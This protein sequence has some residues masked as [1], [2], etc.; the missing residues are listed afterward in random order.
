MFARAYQALH[1]RELLMEE[2]SDFK[3]DRSRYDQAVVLQNEYEAKP[4]LSEELVRFISKTKNEP[5]WMLDIR[6]KGFKLF[7]N[8]A[9]PK[10]GPSLEKLDLNNII[11][12]VKP[13]AEEATRWEDV[14]EEIRKVAERIG[15]PEAERRA[16]G[17]AGFQFDSDMMY[18]KL[19]KEW[20]DHGVIFENMDVAVQ[21]YPELVKKYFMTNC[22]PVN[23]HKFIMLHAA[24]WSGGT[25]IYV[26]KGVRVGMPLQAYFRMN[27]MKGGQFE[28][29]LII[30]DEGGEVGYVE[31]CSSPVYAKD[32][33][34]AGCVEIHVLEGARVRYS[35][36][37]NWSKNT[38][39]LNT[40]RAIVHK[41]GIVEWINGNMGCL[42]GDSKVFTNPKGPV[43]IKDIDSGDKVYVWDDKT[44]RI[45][46][47]VVKNKIFSG[48][49][50]VYKI[51]AGGREI[52]ASANHPFLTLIRRKNNPLHKKG[53]FHYEWKPVGEL[54]TGDLVGITKKL[55]V[56]GKPKLLPEI[57]I[58]KTVKSRNQYSDFEMNTSHLYN[59][60]INIPKETNE[61]FMWLMGILLG[62]GFIDLNQNKINIAT[63][64]KEDYREEMCEIIRDL[65]NYEIT[66]K[67]ERYVI[68]NSKALCELFKKIGFDGN[69]DTKKVPDW[70]FTLPES[71]ILAFLAGY[72]DSD[73]HVQ[74]CAL[75]FT[76]IS[77]GLLEKIKL[78]GINVGFGV[79]RVFKHRE[80]GKVRILGNECNASASWRILFNGKKIK[81]LPIKCLAKKIKA[82]K[83][84]TRR[85]YRTSR[86]LNFSSKVNEEVGF[87]R[88]EKISCL[89]EKPTFDIEVENYHN[90]IANGL[91]VHN[92]HTTMLYPSSV[93]I[94][95]GA[96]SDSLGIAFAA[97]GQN[98]DTGSKVIHAAPNTYSTIKAKSISKDG[99]ITSYRGSVIVTKQA[100]N[101]KCSVVCDA[102]L[103]DEKSVSNTFPFM[104]IDNK[105][106]DIAH[107]A[108]V[109]KIGDDEIH[110]LQSRGLSEEQAMQM[111]VAGFIEPI[112]KALPLE[113]AVE[114]KKL[115]ELEMEGTVG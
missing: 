91:I 45:K 3:I 104:K 80:A 53:F 89:G 94:G 79:S 32:S 48:Y 71:Q 87:A 31:G 51:E 55:P 106:V 90:F 78:L 76:S 7:E 72:F 74:D 85:N 64:E 13:G 22:I 62:D 61:D 114:L 105:S 97:E 18:H 66:E 43:N 21:K 81:E 107:E 37:E 92:S 110:Y 25:F 67:K 84:E 83:I 99:G 8:C 57:E 68:V 59:Q 50:E 75:V 88:I 1:D 96:R 54:K 65:F 35:S 98:Q 42:T 58:G 93:L 100:R 108:T 60:N 34:H 12:F 70:V 15:V 109:G 9:I 33:L 46:K 49:K 20:E 24:V 86:G 10:W 112:V 30:V 115:I 29:T 95:E 40:K 19:K 44:N 11:Y 14:P 28:H 103:L 101:S 52:E 82:D 17:G 63:H 38:Y 47:S 6:L 4:G 69:A 2:M 36:V 16:L 102:L 56:E 5:R 77:K 111:I 73:G 23:D 39:N 41:N 113:Y 26:P 27:A